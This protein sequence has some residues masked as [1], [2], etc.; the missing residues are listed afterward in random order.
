MSEAGLDAVLGFNYLHLV[1]D[2]PGTLRSIHALLASGGLFISKTPCVGD[3]NPFIRLAL[4]SAM[5]TIGKAPHAGVFQASDLGEHICGAGFDIL[6]TESHANKGNESRPYVVARK[7]LHERPRLLENS[8][9]T[10][11]TQI[12][13]SCY[14][15]GWHKSGPTTCHPFSGVNTG[16][17]HYRCGNCGN[18]TLITE[19]EA[20]NGPT[21][22]SQ[23]RLFRE[24]IEIAESG[25]S[26]ALLT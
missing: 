15:M 14:R 18:A 3:M 13:W 11:S 20:I 26:Q 16:K 25:R 4:L 23:S 17:G 12:P 5:R 6:A 22:S 10:F 19:M 7:R 2:L 21:D 9:S 24:P 1:R 8:S